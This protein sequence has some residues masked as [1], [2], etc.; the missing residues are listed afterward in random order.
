MSDPLYYDNDEA[1]AKLG[2][3]ILDMVMGQRLHGYSDASIGHNILCLADEHI[4]EEKPDQE[5][6]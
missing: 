6:G 1:M 4:N 3:D 2:R 5:D